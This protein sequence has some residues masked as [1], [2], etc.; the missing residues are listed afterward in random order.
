MQKSNGRLALLVAGI[1]EI[2]IGV[3]TVI[4]IRFLLSANEGTQFIHNL[5]IA[6]QALLEMVLLYGLC[7]FKVIAGLVAVIFA[8]KPEKYTIL[9]I[10]AGLLVVF[11]VSSL[12]HTGTAEA[13][14]FN[15]ISLL[16]P[17]IY[18]YGAQKHRMSLQ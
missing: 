3:G 6:E 18:M 2:I 12:S 10:L 11:S 1:G 17:S 16:V 5:N 13:W 9:T 4:F 15:A 14:M 7:A 8:N